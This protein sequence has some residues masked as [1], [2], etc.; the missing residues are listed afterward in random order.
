MPQGVVIVTRD[1]T[2]L[3]AAEAALKQLYQEQSRLLA[4]ETAAK[5]ASRLKSEFTANLS[6]EIR[7]P[8]TGMIGMSELLLEED[9]TPAQHDS[10]RKILKSGEILLKM[11]GDVL[12]IGKVEAGK[13]VSCTTLAHLGYTEIRLCIGIGHSTVCPDRPCVRRYYDVQNGRT[14]ERSQVHRRTVKF[15]RRRNFGRLASNAP[16]AVEVSVFKS[17]AQHYTEQRT[18]SFLANSVKFTKQGLIRLRVQQDN[19][20]ADSVETRFV[21]E[22]SGIGIAS[23]VIPMLF[24]PFQQADSTTSR[25]HGGTGLGLAISK[26]LVEMMDGTV[27]MDSELGKGTSI[28]VVVPFRKNLRLPAGLLRRESLKSKGS[29]DSTVTAGSA[30]PERARLSPDAK[31]QMH[32]ALS[33]MMTEAHLAPD[34]P[35]SVQEDARENAGK[36]VPKEIVRKDIWILLAEDNLLNQEIFVRGIKRMGFN[37]HAV[38]NG[39]EALD[40]LE[41][42]DWD[43]LLL[44]WHMPIMDGATATREIRKSTNSRIRNTT[45]IALTA[46][47]VTGDRERCIAAGMDGYLSKP[48]RLKLLEETIMD[49]LSTETPRQ[50]QDSKPA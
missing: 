37:I 26:R 4:S 12:D 46:S 39:K 24:Q 32:T 16:S 29:S 7:T 1:I 3:K 20:T 13:L 49:Y 31:A 42:R 30:T 28:T 44:D 11:V 6:H 38:N 35:A 2:N 5:E 9:M 22:D 33:P 27:T 19:E 45:I 8:I 14:K 18:R 41:E 34:T 40:A 36:A 47:A 23:N 48:V 50:L 10:V 17:D 25:E 21:V 43:L 15:V